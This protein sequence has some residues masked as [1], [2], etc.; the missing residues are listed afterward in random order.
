MKRGVRAIILTRRNLD[1]MRRVRP[2][3]CTRHSRVARSDPTFL[4]PLIRPPSF[5]FP[6]DH[7]PLD[8]C[9][10]VLGPLRYI[11]RALSRNRKGIFSQV[12]PPP[13]A[14]STQLRCMVPHGHMRNY[15]RTDVERTSSRFT[16]ANRE[17]CV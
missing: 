10:V 7:L 6:H 4:F 14:P 5:L 11:R 12:P 15:A 13:P 9:S 17:R 16:Y 3:S 8:T 2:S 1:S